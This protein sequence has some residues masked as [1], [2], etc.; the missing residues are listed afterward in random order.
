MT[1]S[2][3]KG[4]IGWPGKQ[5]DTPEDVGAVGVAFRVYSMLAEALQPSLV[6]VSV[7]VPGLPPSSAI[8]VQVTVTE[9]PVPKAATAEKRSGEDERG[10]DAWL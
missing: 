4:R 8:W 3:A 1:A 10:K 5:A 7:T 9:V 2:S 6:T